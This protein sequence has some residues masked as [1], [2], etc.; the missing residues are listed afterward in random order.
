M[1]STVPAQASDAIVLLGGGYADRTPTVA[2]L[3]RNMRPRLIVL[4][5][6]GGRSGWSKKHQRNLY[7]VEWSEELLIKTGVPREAIVTL[8]HINSGTVYDAL[9]VRDY[10]QKV[11]VGEIML[12]TSDYHTRR[13]L[14]IFRRVLRDLPVSIGIAPAPSPLFSLPAL[15]EP[16]KLMYYWLRYGVFNYMPEKPL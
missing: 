3:F 1:S 9:A 15:K 6:D 8:Q 2:D 11:Q 16:F 7:A 10:L 4:V 13:T 5:K 14:W 12:V